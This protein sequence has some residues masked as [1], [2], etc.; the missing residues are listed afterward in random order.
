MVSH[1]FTEELLSWALILLLIHVC[2][3]VAKSGAN[4]TRMS[5]V[6][7]GSLGSF[8]PAKT[9]F[10]K[11]ARGVVTRCLQGHLFLSALP[12]TQI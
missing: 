5:L 1:S 6:S 8:L 4:V 3:E 9:G 12:D 10:Q 7:S 11:S 2:S